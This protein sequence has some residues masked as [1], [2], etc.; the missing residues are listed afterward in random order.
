[1]ASETTTERAPSPAAAAAA[2]VDW[3]LMERW[4][5]QYYLHNV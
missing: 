3:E 2:K 5:R 1:M 4:D